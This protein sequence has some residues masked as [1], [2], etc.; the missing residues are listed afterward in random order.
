MK[1]F[2]VNK[3]INYGNLYSPAYFTEPQT[4]VRIRFLVA[5]DQLTQHKAHALSAKVFHL[6]TRSKTQIKRV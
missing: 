4:L 1:A 2:R 5:S 6:E 3:Y